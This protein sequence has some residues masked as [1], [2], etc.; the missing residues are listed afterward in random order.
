MNLAAGKILTHIQHRMV[1]QLRIY[2]S[3]A[4]VGVEDF[5]ANSKGK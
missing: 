3:M 2:T 5:E 1:I 4:E